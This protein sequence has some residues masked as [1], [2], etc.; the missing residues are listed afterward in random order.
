MTRPSTRAAFFYLGLVFVAGAL[1]GAAAN[2]F[3]WVQSAAASSRPYGRDPGLYRQQLIQR[4][5]TDLSLDSK[6]IQ[7]VDRIY[8][9]I[10]KRYHDARKI[11]EPEIK[12][13]REERMAQIMA[14]LGPEQQVKYQQIIEKRKQ[15]HKKRK[16][17]SA[18]SCP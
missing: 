2:H 10:G 6:Q 17:K 16:Q 14:V 9:D 1:F 3:Y 8:D 12:I 11:I 5:T 18:A 7:Q 4:L 13:L 15:A